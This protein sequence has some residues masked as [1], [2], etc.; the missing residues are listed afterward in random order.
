[1]S[2]FLYLRYFCFVMFGNNLFLSF[3]SLKNMITLIYIS[4]NRVKSF[5]S[6]FYKCE[7]EYGTINYDVKKS[8]SQDQCIHNKCQQPATGNE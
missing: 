3:L 7:P 8:L 4:I 2:L 6:F 5:F 1:M